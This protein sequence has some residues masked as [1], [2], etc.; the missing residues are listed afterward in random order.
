MYFLHLIYPERN[1]FSL[2]F[3]QSNTCKIRARVAHRGIDFY[4]RFPNLILHEIYCTLSIANTCLLVR[5]RYRTD[6]MHFRSFS[7]TVISLM[8]A[9][10]KNSFLAFVNLYH[11]LSYVRTFC[12]FSYDVFRE[13]RKT[14]NNK[15]IAKPI[16]PISNS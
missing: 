3:K 13:K 16:F 10:F 1:S 8:S 2:Y 4:T 9:R 14:K 11:M 12:A 15:F 5:S 7:I 6:F